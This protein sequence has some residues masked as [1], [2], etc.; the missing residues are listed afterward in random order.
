LRTP[1]SIYRDTCKLGTAIPYKVSIASRTAAGGTTG[2]GWRSQGKM[3][4][5]RPMFSVLL[6]SVLALSCLL[7]PASAF[8]CPA[9]SSR[10]HRVGN[11]PRSA[12]GKSQPMWQAGRSTRVAGGVSMVTRMGGIFGASLEE[13]LKR[14]AWGGKAPA[15]EKYNMEVVLCDLCASLNRFCFWT[16]NILYANS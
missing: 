14:S 9:T 13:G 3:I 12:C 2:A 4:T 15:I 5:T 8:S 16:R 10:A 11:D 1:T 6:A 7:H